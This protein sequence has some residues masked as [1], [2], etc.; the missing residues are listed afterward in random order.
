MGSPATQAS[1][2]TLEPPSFKVTPVAPSM[3]IVEASFSI[4]NASSEQVDNLYVDL[5]SL[6]EYVSVLDNSIFAGDLN[7]ASSME[8][9]GFRIMLSSNIPDQEDIKLRVSIKSDNMEW[10]YDQG[11]FIC[12]IFAC[13]QEYQ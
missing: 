7:P 9:S 10:N 1:A 5:L 8:L 11:Q 12:L 6:S 13:H 2:I 4:N 3:V